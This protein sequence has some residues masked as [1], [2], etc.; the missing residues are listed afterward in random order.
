MK[1]NSG[2]KMAHE[3]G[4]SLNGLPSISKPFVWTAECDRTNENVLV[5]PKSSHIFNGR[6]SLICMSRSLL[7]AREGV[8][9][10]ACVCVCLCVCERGVVAFIVRVLGV[11]VGACVK[12][13]MYMGVCV[14]ADWCWRRQS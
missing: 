1:W 3:D 13:S 14:F 8:C 6:L 10:C 11:G 5:G 7:I 9:V 4:V 12:G 2:N